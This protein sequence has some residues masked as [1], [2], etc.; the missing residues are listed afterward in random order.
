[1][2]WLASDWRTQRSGILLTATPHRRIFP[3][4][5]SSLPRMDMAVVVWNGSRSSSLR[6]MK[7]GRSSA[8]QSPTQLE[9]EISGVLGDLAEP[10]LQHCPRRMPSCM[11]RAEYRLTDCPAWLA[12]QCCPSS[13]EQCNAIPRVGHWL[14]GSGTVPEVASTKSTVGTRSAGRAHSSR[15]GCL[16][17]VRGR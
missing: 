5:G 12:W 9:I 13:K 17:P 15:N 14:P 6:S 8:T 16:L 7:Q 3:T 11:R 1:M 2:L 10:L 4:A